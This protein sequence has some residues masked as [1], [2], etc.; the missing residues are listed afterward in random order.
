MVRIVKINPSV[1]TLELQ[2]ETI[3]TSRQLPLLR[4][5]VTYN[6]I[7]SPETIEKQIFPGRIFHCSSLAI[8]SRKTRSLFEK[9]PPMD[10][11]HFFFNLFKLRLF[12]ELKSSLNPMP[13]KV[14]LPVLFKSEPMWDRFHSSI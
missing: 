6:D 2:V 12:I 4:Y 3:I 7:E 9:F 14:F 13:V 5:I 8:L 11:I 10:L 1:S